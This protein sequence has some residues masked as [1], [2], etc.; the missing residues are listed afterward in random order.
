FVHR[1]TPE[2]VLLAERLLRVADVATLD[3]RGHGDSDGAFTFGC[4]E[5][6]DVAG[7]A[8]ALAR[9]YERV[10]GLGFSFGGYHPAVAAAL[11][12]PFAAVALVAA[13][14]SLFILDH[15]FLT[16]GLAASLPHM[17]RRRRR[18]TRLSFSPLGRRHAPE[19]LVDRIAPV[20][21][22]VAHGTGDW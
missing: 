21:L 4:R 7:L 14:G 9:E 18:R 2:H 17:L 3:V 20:P 11:H 10:G 16:R 12:R 5:P 1:H 6:E 13:P 22:L 19:R 15:N 8:A